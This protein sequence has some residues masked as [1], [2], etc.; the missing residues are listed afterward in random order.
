MT[1]QHTIRRR[2]AATTPVVLAALLLVLPSLATLPASLPAADDGTG[3]IHGVHIR[4][5][6]VKIQ[7]NRRQ[8]LVHHPLHIGGIKLPQQDK[9]RDAPVCYDGR[10]GQLSFLAGADDFQHTEHVSFHHLLD[11]LFI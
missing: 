6:A 7:Q 3:D 11:Q 4:T 2:M 5:V 8:P 10:Q 9:R 1:S